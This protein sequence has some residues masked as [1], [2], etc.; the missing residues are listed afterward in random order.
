S[1]NVTGPAVVRFKAR[2]FNPSESSA[3]Q[4]TN[5]QPRSV[6]V[7]G[8][9][10]QVRGYELSA[11]LN[12]LGSGMGVIGS[13]PPE[14]TSLSPSGVA[15]WTEVRMMIPAGSHVLKWRLSELRTSGWSSVLSRHSYSGGALQGEVADLR[16]ERP[17]AFFDQWMAEKEADESLREPSE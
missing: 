12:D 7:I 3:A 2:C 1:T 10:D 5:R 6:I 15:G 4:A 8:G 13:R 11:W 17:R 16:I 14:I 9:G